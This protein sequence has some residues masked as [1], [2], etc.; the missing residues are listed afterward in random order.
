MIP[1]DK[2]M[3][4][5]RNTH[6]VLSMKD[7]IIKAIIYNVKKLLCKGGGEFVNCHLNKWGDQV[8]YCEGKNFLNTSPVYVSFTDHSLSSP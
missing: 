4:R 1:G 7:R 2:D 8:E 5:D 6:M 3:R